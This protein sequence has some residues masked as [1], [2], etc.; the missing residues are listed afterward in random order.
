MPNL[1]CL[2]HFHCGQSTG[3]N[4]HVFPA[5]LG[6]RRTDSRLI[7]DDCQGWTSELDEVLPEQLRYLNLHLGVVGDHRT[8]PA[9]ISIPDGDSG[10]QFI[11]DEK[12]NI[13]ARGASL[14]AERTDETGQTVRRYNFLSKAEERRVLNEL[15]AQGLEVQVLNREVTPILRTRPLTSHLNFGGAQGMRATARIALNFLAIQEP[16]LGRRCLSPSGD[17]FF[18]ANR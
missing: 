9:R 2:F 5:A 12:M 6:G 7:C 11:L 17:G 10:R 18:R 15:R 14:I 16:Q 4:E 1:E 8:R 3:S 13:E